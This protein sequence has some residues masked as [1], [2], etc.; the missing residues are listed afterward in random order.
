MTRHGQ[1]TRCISL[2]AERGLSLRSFEK[3][4]PKS[5]GLAHNAFLAGTRA[6][7]ELLAANLKCWLE[8]SFSS[9][10]TM[11]VQRPEAF[12][13]ASSAESTR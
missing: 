4:G 11:G 5:G 12:Q 8:G 10:T 3:T 7:A 6:E 2:P 1:I 9:R 13:P